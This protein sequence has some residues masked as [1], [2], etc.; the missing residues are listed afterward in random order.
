MARRRKHAFDEDRIDTVLSRDF[1]F[2]GRLAF[3]G[4][5]LIKGE[6]H[7]EV[8]AEEGH[9]YIDPEATVEARIR[10]ASLSCRGQ[11]TGDVEA[12]GALHILGS[13][14]IDGDVITT[15]L[16]VESGAVLN[17]NCTFLK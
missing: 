14:R 4:S 13:G 2:E 7:G 17:G 5:L 10:C 12:R 6:L 3:K 8:D 11:I 15:D 16:Q 1:V 9:L